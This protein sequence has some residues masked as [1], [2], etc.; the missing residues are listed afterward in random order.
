MTLAVEGQSPLNDLL[1]AA[2]PSDVN[3]NVQK[4]LNQ[5]GE[6]YT[7]TYEH[8]IDEIKPTDSISNV[9]CK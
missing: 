4:T 1:P 9:Y 6:C 5:G 8:F 7:L 3:A 2:V